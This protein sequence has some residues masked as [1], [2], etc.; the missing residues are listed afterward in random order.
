[1]QLRESIFLTESIHLQI[2]DDHVYNTTVYRLLNENYNL[3]IDND[4]YISHTNTIG[5]S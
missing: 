2:Y 1:M 4:L 3:D 5:Q